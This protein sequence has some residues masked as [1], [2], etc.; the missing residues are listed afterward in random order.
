MKRL[1]AW[2]LLVAGVACVLLGFAVPALVAYTLPPTLS[3]V[4]TGM[5]VGVGVSLIA[6][7]LLRRHLPAACDAAPMPLRQRYTRAMLACMVCYAATLVVSMLLLKRT[8]LAPWLRAVVALAPAV[9]IAFV[10]NT[11]IGYIR[12]V[13]EMQQRIEIESVS[14][15]TALLCLLYMGGGFLQLAKVIDI[16]AG[17]AMIWVFPLVCLFYGVAKVVVARRFG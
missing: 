17:V 10:L 15:A 7:A 12:A 4:I 5:G 2:Q 9:P 8:D 13:D 1:R 6:A 16:P 11:I 14:F 3:G